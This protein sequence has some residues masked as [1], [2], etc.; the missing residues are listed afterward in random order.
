MTSTTEHGVQTRKF[1]GEYGHFIGGEW[2]SGAAGKLIEQSNPATGEVVGRIQAGDATD[3]RRAVAAAAKAFPGWSATSAE[4]RGEILFEISRRLNARINDYARM[5]SIN[6]GKTVT[7]AGSWDVPISSRCFSYFAGAAQLI[8]GETLDFPDSVCI[9][10]REP[11][12]VCAQIIPWNVPLLMASA[13]IAPALAA[14]NTVILKPAETTCLTV[15]EFIADIAD[16]L[17]PGVVNV[18]TGYGAEVGEALVTHPSVRKVA[19]TGSTATGRR[20]LQYA[21]H[22]L[23]PQTLELG[24]KSAQIVCASADIDAAVEGAAMS[25]LFN[26]G[27]VCLAG[28]RVFVHETVKDEFLE[29]LVRV[30]RRIRV[31]DPLDPAT[32]LGAQASKAQFEKIRGYLQIAAD[33]G[34]VAVTG[35]DV[36]VVQGLPR[37]MFIQPT[38]LDKVTPNMRVA[39]EEI[40]GPVT[41]ILTWSDEAQLL[42]NVNASE[43]GLGGGLWSRDLV[44]VH[45]MAR[46]IETGTIWVNRY[47]NFKMGMPLG[48][49]KQSGFGR[50]F[51][52]EILDAYTI[53]KSVVI[54]LSQGPLGLFN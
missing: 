21:S 20:I 24:G 31:G 29:K 49:Y 40:F 5:E 8:H 42:A 19:F 26:K 32:Q 50:E 18:V 36:A 28:S 38:I 2:V 3:V 44:E 14:G 7:E 47:Y 34:A 43:Y 9:N 11:I 1:R 25:T 13:K 27:E 53:T 46:A 30:M 41:S 54:N 35:G 33:E 37:G 39:R 17:P 22:N 45:R 6:N 23:I 51:A 16:L 12:G 4:Q 52:R 15:L 48:G 10:H